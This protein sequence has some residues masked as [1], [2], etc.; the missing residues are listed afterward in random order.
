M[1][2]NRKLLEKILWWRRFIGEIPSLLSTKQ[3]F[4]YRLQSTSR[5]FVISCYC[6]EEKM[7]L[8]VFSLECLKLCSSTLV[9]HFYVSCLVTE[10]LAPFSHPIRSKTN[11]SWLASA[12]FPALHANHVLNAIF[13]WFCLHYT[14]EHTQRL[15]YGRVGQP[16]PRSV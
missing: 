4:F 1:N 14:T 8:E 9:L 15:R 2:Q 3:V 13:D 12:R 7:M 10:A 5:S 11:Q 6:W 16:D